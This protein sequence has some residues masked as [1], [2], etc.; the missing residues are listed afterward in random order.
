MDSTLYI[1][2]S[3]MF[4]KRPANNSKGDSLWLYIKSQL[5]GV[6]DSPS[7]WSYS[8]TSCQGSFGRPGTEEPSSGRS[9]FPERTSGQA[10]HQSFRIKAYYIN[11]RET[12]ISLFTIQF[13]HLYLT[14]ILSSDLLQHHLTHII[15]QVEVMHLAQCC[16]QARCRQCVWNL[17]PAESTTPIRTT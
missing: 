12:H 13:S 14:L 5:V 6:C 2:F 16:L 10:L 8:Y 15:K 4:C 7:E 1:V 9:W 11:Q 17:K 3:V